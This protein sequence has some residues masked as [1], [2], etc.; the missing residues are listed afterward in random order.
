MRFL[1]PHHFN[2]I[3]TNTHTNIQQSS[4]NNI[5]ITYITYINLF[6]FHSK[7]H[8]IIIKSFDTFQIIQYQRSILSKVSLMYFI[9]VLCSS[10]QLEVPIYTALCF[11]S[12][13]M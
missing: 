5:D 12:I 8:S 13:D 4:F 9:L 7:I 6:S 11:N 1:F 10:Y 2:T 3:R